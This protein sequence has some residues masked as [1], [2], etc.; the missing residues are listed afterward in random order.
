MRS[1]CSSC[2]L[3]SSTD[4]DRVETS[5]RWSTACIDYTHTCG[6]AHTHVHTHTRTATATATHRHT[7]ALASGHADGRTPVGTPRTFDGS[8][9]GMGDAS[10]HFAL[11]RR[12]RCTVR[13][14]QHCA[15][16]PGRAC[17]TPVTLVCEACLATN[18]GRP[19]A[20]EGCPL[21]SMNVASARG[22]VRCMPYGIVHTR[23]LRFG[24]H[25]HTRTLA[26]LLCA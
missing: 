15:C 16:V 6:R 23:G 12:R 9:K 26:L 5:Q 2:R 17:A 4:I 21:Y 1:K 19:R 22:S 8:G 24:L 7:H 25:S 14:Y 18:P 11:D 20:Q 10:R 13:V 3:Q